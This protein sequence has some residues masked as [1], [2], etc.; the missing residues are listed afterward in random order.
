MHSSCILHLCGWRSGAATCDLHRARFLTCRGQIQV[1]LGRVYEC[2]RA[3]TGSRHD[4]IN[5]KSFAGLMT[6]SR[7]QDW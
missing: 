7:A 5:F 1:K 2:E 3:E 4:E 6:V